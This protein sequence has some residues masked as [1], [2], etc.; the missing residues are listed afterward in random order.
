VII[1]CYVLMGVMYILQR[2]LQYFKCFILQRH[3]S[4]NSKDI[5]LC[6]F[7]WKCVCRRHLTAKVSLMCYEI[8]S[9]NEYIIMYFVKRAIYNTIHASYLDMLWPKITYWLW[10]IVV[11]LV[12]AMVNDE[13]FIL[14]KWR[15]LG[16]CRPKVWYVLIQGVYCVRSSGT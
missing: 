8:I 1:L 11:D 9:A 5:Y 3:L 12:F 15:E 6:W 16:T 2:F 7:G 14:V 4:S 13:G 10:T